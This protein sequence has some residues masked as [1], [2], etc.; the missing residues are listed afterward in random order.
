MDVVLKLLDKSCETR[1]GSGPNDY[2][3]IINHPFFA[4]IDKEALLRGEV[5]PPPIPN[6]RGG[7]SQINEYGFDSKVFNMR[8]NEKDLQETVLPQAK[9]DTLRKNLHAF[10]DFDR[11][12]ADLSQPGRVP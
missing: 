6:A 4:D 9:L 5:K 11:Q 2:L 7:P 12:G 10:D 1:L 8:S 3:D